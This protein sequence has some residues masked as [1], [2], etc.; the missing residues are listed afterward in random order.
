MNLLNRLG[1]LVL[2]T[3]GAGILFGSMVCFTGCELMGDL[4]QTPDSGQT[5]DPVDVSLRLDEVFQDKAHVRLNHEG[6]QDAF[7]YYMLTEDFTTDAT[8]LLAD[9]IKQV[10]DADGVLVGNVGTNKNITFEGLQARTKYRVIAAMVSPDGN[11]VGEAVEIDFVTLRDPDVF[12]VCD[13]WE[14]S[15][16]KRVSAENDANQETEV[17]ECLV[18][19]DTTKT[20]IPCVLAK[21]DFVQYYGS[22]L[23]KC[24]E[25]YIEYR[26]SFQVKWVQ[27]VR[28]TSSEYTQDRMLS[29]QYM[30]F[31][32]GVDTAGDLTGYYAQTEFDLKQEAA[33]KTYDDWSGTWI[34]RGDC[35]NKT[36]DGQTRTIEYEI[37]IVPT[38]TN[39]YFELYG[40][41]ARTFESLK[42]IPYTIPLT[43][44]FEKS[45]GDVYVISEVLPDVP[46]NQALAD[47][48]NFYSYGSV[49]VIYYD[50]LT[51]IPVDIANM[52][53][54]RFSM[55]DSSHARAYNTK[56]SIDL[57]G[58]SYN[59]EFVAFNYFYE[60]LGLFNYILENASYVLRT[61]TITLTKK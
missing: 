46:N 49:E 45:S 40:Y 8:Q 18:S 37:D 38:E 27:E 43:L 60:S 1:R 36:E 42:E 12:E 15:Y 47:L 50:V 24:F 33:L 34:L 19:G 20:Y 44:Y 48:W 6:A 11:I 29:G 58:E 21:S 4:I 51:V 35:L 61:D 14:I 7:W 28:R 57:Y 26:N 13:A 41:D 10:L 52:R 54:A 22:D 17:F 31:M 55:E 9:K 3:I 25:D 39:L 30:L 32:I 56:V 2:S 53:I 59:T 5:I 16:K 23:R